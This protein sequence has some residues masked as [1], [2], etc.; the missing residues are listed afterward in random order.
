MKYK[1]TGVMICVDATPTLT[2]KKKYDVTY[3]TE[4]WYGKGKTQKHLATHVKLKNDNGRNMTVDINR[5]SE[6]EEYN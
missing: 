2:N 6:I 1:L 5:F 3:I 4:Y